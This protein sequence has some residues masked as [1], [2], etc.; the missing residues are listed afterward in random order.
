MSDSGDVG[1]GSS[2]GD[3]GSV[4]DEA[5]KLLGALTDWARDQG[6]TAGHGVTDAAS[7]ASAALHDATAHFATGSAECTYCPICRVVH[8]VREA[9]PEVR[10]HLAVAALNLMQAASAVL[11]TTVPAESR[12]DARSEEVEKI[13]LDD[14]WPDE[15]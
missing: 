2:A 11:A 12:P 4:A 1:A 5:A 13:D 6:S 15:D 3:V 8:V 14:D 9:S 7:A 10:T